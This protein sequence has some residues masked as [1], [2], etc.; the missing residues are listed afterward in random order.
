MSECNFW[1]RAGNTQWCDMIQKTCQCSGW[2]ECCDMKA[3][4]RQDQKADSVIDIRPVIA[5][6]RRK[7]TRRA[8]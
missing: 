5:G 4:S 2:D 3:A 7:K 1:W 6:R 8:A